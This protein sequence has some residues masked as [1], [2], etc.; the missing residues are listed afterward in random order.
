ML[1]SE[2]AGEADDRR[3]SRNRHRI[4]LSAF[5]FLKTSRFVKTEMKFVRG[6]NISTS[7]RVVNK[8]HRGWKCYIV[9][10]VYTGVAP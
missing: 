10:P 6:F 8:L 4:V 5:M 3:S 2:H 7:Q 9:G 1:S